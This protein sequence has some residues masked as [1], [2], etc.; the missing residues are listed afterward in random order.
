M[1]G[2]HQYGKAGDRDVRR[3]E[4]E[5][6]GYCRSGLRLDSRSWAVHPF[7]IAESIHKDM[8]SPLQAT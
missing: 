8:S 3:V 7:E 1:A 4:I 2:S 6:I 5:D